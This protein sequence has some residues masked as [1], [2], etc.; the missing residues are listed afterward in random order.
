[1]LCFKQT[2]SY[3]Q[4]S[5]KLNFVSHLLECRKIAMKKLT[6]MLKQLKLKPDHWLMK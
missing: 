6:K 1:M 5:L 3:Q 4:N 2:N